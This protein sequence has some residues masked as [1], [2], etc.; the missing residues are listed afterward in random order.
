MHEVFPLGC[1]Y[2]QYTGTHANEG[3]CVFIWTLRLFIAVLLYMY[4]NNNL[5]HHSPIY[6]LGYLTYIRMLMIMRYICVY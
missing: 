6:I 4:M 1:N 5:K 2:L 3:D